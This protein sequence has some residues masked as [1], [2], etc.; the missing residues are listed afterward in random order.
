MRNAMRSVTRTVMRTATTVEGAA[1]KE[2]VE[3]AV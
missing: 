3:F 1:G 2:T